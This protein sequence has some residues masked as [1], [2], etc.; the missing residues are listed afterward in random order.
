[1]SSAP[2][3]TPSSLNWTPTTPTLS[4][5]FADTVIVPETVA[6]ADGAVMETIGGGGS[7]ANGTLTPPAVA[8]VAAASRGTAGG[9]GGPVAA[10]GGGPGAALRGPHN[11]GAAVGPP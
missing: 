7:F 6:P 9:G 11:S 5:A 4:V 8:G 1:M 10:V 2:R 3:L